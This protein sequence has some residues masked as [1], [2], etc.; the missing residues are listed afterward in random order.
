MNMI[1]AIK[2]LENNKK[3]RKTYWKENEYIF[4]SKCGIIV[5]QDGNNAPTPIDLRDVWEVF[6]NNSDSPK[7][8]K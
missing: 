5:D 8:I 6:E 2:C 4:I 7:K 1:E 3:I